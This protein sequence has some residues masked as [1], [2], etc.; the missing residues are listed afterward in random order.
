MELFYSLNSFPILVMRWAHKH[1]LEHSAACCARA[2]ISAWDQ[3]GGSLSSCRQCSWSMCN[4][5]LAPIDFQPVTCAYGNLNHCVWPSSN[6]SCCKLP[7]YLIW[8]LGVFRLKYLISFWLICL[9]VNPWV[10]NYSCP[11]Q[12]ED[13]DAAVI[14]DLFKHFG[15]S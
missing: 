13:W 15:G 8:L 7:A 9:Y 14:T 6:N 2:E 12:C 3:E 5:S 10:D 1:L 4:R 11:L